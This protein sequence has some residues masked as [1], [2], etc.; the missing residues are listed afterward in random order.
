MALG[1][2]RPVTQFACGRLFKI[3]IAQEHRARLAGFDH[4]QNR[5]G[6]PNEAHTHQAAT[7]EKDEPGFHHKK[8]TSSTVLQNGSIICQNRRNPPPFSL[9]ALKAFPHQF[10][11]ARAILTS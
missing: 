9:Q 6:A 11:S 8:S 4:A 1:R 5:L 2:W 3:S 7:N 10:P